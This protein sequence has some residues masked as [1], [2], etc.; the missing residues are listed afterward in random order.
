MYFL[1]V[2]GNVGQRGKDGSIGPFG[3]SGLKGN[4]VH[5]KYNLLYWNKL[6][7]INC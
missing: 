4:W 5:F 2:Q 1:G 7:F 3:P 6:H